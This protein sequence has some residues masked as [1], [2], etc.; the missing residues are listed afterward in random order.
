MLYWPIAFLDTIRHIL[1]SILVKK[2]SEIADI[3]QLLPKWHFEEWKNTPTKHTI[4]FP[5]MK[6]YAGIIPRK[7]SFCVMLDMAYVFD[8]V[9]HSQ[10]ISNLLKRRLNL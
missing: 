8:N 3:H 7:N 4:Y 5:V 10:L 1:E 9:F 6:I 2:M